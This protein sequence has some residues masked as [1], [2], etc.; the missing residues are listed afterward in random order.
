MFAT[1]ETVGQV[2][3]II[4]DTFLDISLFPYGQMARLDGSI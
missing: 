4:D 1:G 3:W 2:E